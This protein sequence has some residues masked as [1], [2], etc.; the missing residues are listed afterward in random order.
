MSSDPWTVEV[1]HEE[2]LIGVCDVPTQITHD[3]AQRLS[4]QLD[5]AADELERTRRCKEC[6]GV[7]VASRYTPYRAFCGDSCRQRAYRKRKRDEA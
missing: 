3:E 7:F 2:G 4:K 6:G 5:E 1:R